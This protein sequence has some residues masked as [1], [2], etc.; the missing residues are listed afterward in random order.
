[1]AGNEEAT[2]ALWLI[3]SWSHVCRCIV[4]YQLADGSLLCTLCFLRSVMALSPGFGFLLVCLNL[5]NAEK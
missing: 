3:D 4:V 5:I 1:M 2:K